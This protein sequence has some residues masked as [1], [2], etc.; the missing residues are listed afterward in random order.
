MPKPQPYFGKVYSVTVEKIKRLDCPSFHWLWLTVQKFWFS[1]P[2]AQE[3]PSPSYRNDSVFSLPVSL[4]NVYLFQ[5]FGQG[6]DG[7]AVNFT[8]IVCRA[9]VVHDQHHLFR[10]TIH[11]RRGPFTLRVSNHAGSRLNL[12]R[13]FKRHQCKREGRIPIEVSENLFKS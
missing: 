1:F 4:T 5:V 11:R 10:K 9:Q 2:I 3:S 13:I 6:R 8:W 7:M 12:A